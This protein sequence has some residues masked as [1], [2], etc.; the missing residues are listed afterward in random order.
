VIH[1]AT[2]HFRDPRWVGQQLRYLERHADEE[3][4]VYAFLYGEKLHPF[5]DRFFY[6]TTEPIK[7]HAYKLN[8]LADVIRFAAP[9]PDD[10]LLFLDGDAFPLAPL[11]ATLRPRLAKHPLVAV[12]RD[13]NGSPF[14]HPCFA[15]TTVGFWH[16]IGGTWHS[17]DTQ[18]WTDPNGK[19]LT[20]VGANLLTILRDRQIAWHPLLRSNT[21]NPH[22]LYYAVYGDEET[23]AIVYHHG[24]G[25]RIRPGR[26]AIWEAGYADA[27][28]TLRARVLDRL[29]RNWGI[30]RK[31][32]RRYHPVRLL[33][34][35]LRR[36]VKRLDA[37]TFERLSTDEEFWRDFV[38]LEAKAPA[39]EG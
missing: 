22:P 35:E 18:H 6:A 30:T 20:D 21:W 25:F 24:A 11:G 19:P 3:V 9:D 16:E 34:Q 38:D 26:A 2:V 33:A 37:E 14:P 15:A 17:G 7:P 10:I 8:L 12:R 1:V 13:E 32:R 28:K 27:S 4:R 31:L 36:E 23:P 5:A 39:R 29:P